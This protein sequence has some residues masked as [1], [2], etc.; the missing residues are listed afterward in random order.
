MQHSKHSSSNFLTRAVNKCSGFYSSKW[1][2]TCLTVLGIPLVLE[3]VNGVLFPWTNWESSIRF[4]SFQSRYTQKCFRAPQT[5]KV[6]SSL[7]SS[8]SCCFQSAEQWHSAFVQTPPRSAGS[9]PD[10]LLGSS[11]PCLHVGWLLLFLTLRQKYISLFQPKLGKVR[12]STSPGSEG[13]GSDLSLIPCS[14]TPPPRHWAA[15]WCTSLWPSGFPQ[16]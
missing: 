15:I 14:A 8:R 12:P 7:L 1:L 3:S 6:E 10:Q 16:G 5:S 2:Q 13:K 11:T 9:P 4:T